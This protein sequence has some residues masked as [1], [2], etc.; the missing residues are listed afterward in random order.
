MK[1]DIQHED[2]DN[3]G[4]F[5]AELDP[6]HIAEITYIKPEPNLRVCDHT[7]VPKA[8]EGQGIAFQLLEALVEDARKNQIKYVPLC[9]YVA[10]QFGRHPDWADVFVSG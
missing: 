4:R 10:V 1:L 6:S 8:F 3:K 9:P 7:G 5:F 2:N